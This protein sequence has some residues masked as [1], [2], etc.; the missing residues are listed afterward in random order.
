MI[1]IVRHGQT[2]WNVVGRFQGRKDISLNETG[3]KQA[4]ELKDK[5]NSCDKIFIIACGSSYYSSLI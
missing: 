3:I 2:D 4:E 1:Y 5:L